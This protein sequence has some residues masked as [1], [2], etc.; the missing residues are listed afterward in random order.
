MGW[1][2]G[3]IAPFIFLLGAQPGWTQIAGE[4]ETRRDG[5]HL[6]GVT[7][8]TGYTSL[9]LPNYNYNYLLGTV[10]AGSDMQFG[11]AISVGL[12]RFR[13][14]SSFSLVY[15]SSYDGL[16]RHSE[17]NALNH[18]LMLS[19]GR[20]FGRRWDLHFSAVGT[21]SSMYQY[22]FAPSTLSTVAAV[23][24]SFDDLASAVLAG[25]FTN[26][27]LAS[28][29]TGAPVM[30][31]PDR[32]ALYGERVLNVSSAITASYSRSDRFTVR[33]SGSA[34]RSQ[35][36]NVGNESTTGIQAA[37]Q[38]TTDGNADVGFSYAI[39][40]RTDFGIDAG[41][42][43][44]I[45]VFQDTYT[46]TVLAS[47]GR[48]IG[49]RWLLTGRAGPAWLHP[50]RQAYQVSRGTQVAGGGS[51]GYKTY[52]QSI[53]ATVDRSAADMYGTMAGY[54][55]STGGAWLWHHPGSQWSLSS[56]VRQQRMRGTIYEDLDG[57]MV[58]ASIYR[59]LGLQTGVQITYTYL[60]DS[61]TFL[62]ATS[63][64][65]V[66]SVRVAFLW[67]GR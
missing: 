37:L 50:V 16:A 30:E 11:G 36:L 15:D 29:L 24:A 47:I 52:S 23:P 17:W 46:G 61:G 42:N 19:A 14:G 59:E 28:A 3:I 43:R 55:L 18:A 44:S 26:E 41:A 21:A 2:I 22:L 12:G 45:S 6:Y 38:R 40:P 49:R 10:P 4:Q 53:L 66:H 33:F 34:W 51:F 56:S 39:T 5:L 9:G 57:W 32:T 62:G 31:S 64:I 1:R 20:R 65:A 25:R 60:N 58:S 63:A 7:A 8:Y 13:P 54:T 67:K 48:K 35:Y 27:Q